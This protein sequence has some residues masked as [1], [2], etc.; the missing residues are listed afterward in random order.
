MSFQRLK[1][2]GVHLELV[3]PFAGQPPLGHLQACGFKVHISECLEAYSKPQF[4]IYEKS[5]SRET[6]FY[7]PLTRLLVLSKVIKY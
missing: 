7:L 5:C 1:G 4:P 2:I 6:N 3:R